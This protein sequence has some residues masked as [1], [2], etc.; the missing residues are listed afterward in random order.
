[1]DLIRHCK[2]PRLDSLHSANQQKG[3]QVSDSIRIPFHF[4]SDS[5]WFFP[6]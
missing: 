2:E 5:F 1:M 4:A 3:F 6:V